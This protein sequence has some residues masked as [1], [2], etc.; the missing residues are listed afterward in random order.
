M[1]CDCYRATLEELAARHPGTVFVPATVPLGHAKRGLDVLAREMLGRVNQAKLKNRARHSFN[2][3]LRQSWTRFR[4]STPRAPRPLP[5]TAAATRSPI[6][7]R[8]RRTWS[9]VYTDYGGQL[10]TIGRRA[11]AAAF[12]QTLAAAVHRRD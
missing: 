2:E 10:N 11:V 6:E 9:A 8:R 7:A 1:L 3:R 5:P 4:S 12:L